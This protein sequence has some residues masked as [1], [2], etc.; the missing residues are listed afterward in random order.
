MEAERLAYTAHSEELG[1]LLDKDC[2]LGKNLGARPLL[3]EAMACDDEAAS[4]KR[5]MLHHRVA[6]M[7]ARLVTEYRDERR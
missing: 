2:M 7:A 4:H 3:V 6:E 5:T 1:F